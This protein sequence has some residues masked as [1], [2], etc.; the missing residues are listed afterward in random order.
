MNFLIRS[1]RLLGVIAAGLALAFAANAAAAAATDAK[2][3][4]CAPNWPG[5]IVKAE[6]AHQIL[7]TLGYRSHVTSAS[8][9]ICLKGVADRELDVD[10]ALWRPTQNSVLDPMLKSGKVQLLATNVKDAMYDLVVPDYVYAAGV[11]SIA[12]LAKHRDRFDGKIYGI[13]AGNDGNQLVLDAIR[14]NQYGLGAFRLVES[15]EAG[16]LSQAGDAIKHRRWV[17]FLGWKPH[18]MNIIYQLEYLDDPELMWGGASTV[19]TV[20]RPDYGQTQPNVTRL[21]RQMAIPAEVQ[22]QWIYDYGYK[23]IPATDVAAKWLKANGKL[24]GTWLDGVT[25]ADGSR[26]ALDALVAAGKVDAVN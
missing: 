10:M 6:V 16:M 17:V 13:E 18:W 5:E 14:D 8:W 1:R 24:L 11:H 26:G 20:V 7:D 2:V 19:N 21:F 15:S 25:T 12:D 23:E 3:G 9:I 22:S 4:L